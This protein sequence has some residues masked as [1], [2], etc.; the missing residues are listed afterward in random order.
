MEAQDERT[1]TVEHSADDED[2]PE[3][4][5][6]AELEASVFMTQA[7]NQR[8]E[9]EPVRGF[10]PQSDRPPSPAGAREEA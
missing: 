6:A 9:V 2:W 4:L 1:P 3:E 5:L 7:K 10:L 8:A